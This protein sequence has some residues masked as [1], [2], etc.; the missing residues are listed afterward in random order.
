[1]AQFRIETVLDPKTNRC[2]VKVYKESES[3]PFAAGN[4]IC[5]SHEHAMAYVLEIFKKGFP[6]QP[7]TA[8]PINL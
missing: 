2:F 7:I 6:D 3:K 8:K 5:L 4:P 1:M